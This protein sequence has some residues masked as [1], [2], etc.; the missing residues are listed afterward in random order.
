MD[1]DYKAIA[2]NLC[3]QAK[4]VLPN[5]LNDIQKTY[6]CKKVKNHVL[7]AA[8]ALLNQENPAYAEHLPFVTQIIAEWTLHKSISLLSAGVPTA[9]CEAILQKVAFTAYEVAKQAIAALCPQDKIILFVEKYV[10]RI[11][12]EEI[13]KLY[14]K[15]LIDVY[16]K[17]I[18]LM[19]SGNGELSEESKEEPSVWWLR[20]P[21]MIFLLYTCILLPVKAEILLWPVFCCISGFAALYLVYRNGGITSKILLVL[22]GICMVLIKWLQIIMPQSPYAMVFT[23]LLMGIV[24]GAYGQE[25]LAELG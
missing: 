12:S 18:A 21:S 1:I 14:E 3:T 19:D 9:Y 25:R 7:L 13:L 15:N 23:L 8:E 6:V 4:E 22:V 11:Y 2:E 16:T 5:D 20:L 10:N 17:D 24:T